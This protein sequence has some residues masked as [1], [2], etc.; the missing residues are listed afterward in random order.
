MPG[1]IWI[2]LV[3]FMFAMLIAGGI[4]A[5]A[6]ARAALGNLG[7]LSVHLRKVLEA[8]EQGAGDTPASLPAVTKPLADTAER[9]ENV[10]AQKL[11]RKQDRK[12]RH[13]QNWQRW[14]KFNSESQGEV[15]AAVAVSANTD[16]K[17]HEGGNR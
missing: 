9:Y 17:T 5:F 3:I 8:V 10:H 1:W 4:Y 12:A 7:G 15:R 16:A 14:E 2:V 11:Q 13:V 6:K